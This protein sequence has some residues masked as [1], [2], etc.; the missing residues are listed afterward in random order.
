MKTLKKDAF[1]QIKDFYWQ[2]HIDEIG[3]KPVFD[4]SDGAGLNKMIDYLFSLSDHKKVD[5][6][7][8]MFKYILIHWEDLDM[9]Y[10]KNTRLRQINGNIHNIIHFFKNG[11]NKSGVSSDY[12][13][14]VVREMRDSKGDN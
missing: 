10:R 7:V 12:L 2:W 6:V 4:K 8:N 14:R 3:F 1:N 13:E 11:K 9:F 5:E